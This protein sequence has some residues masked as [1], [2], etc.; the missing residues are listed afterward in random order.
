MNT[1]L[2]LREKR[3][4]IWNTAKEFLDQKRGADGIVP[5]EAAAEY[6]KME[7]D[8]VALG[9]EIER[10][11][12]QQAARQ[13]FPSQTRRPNRRRRKR[14]APATSTRRISAAICT[15]KPFC[16]TS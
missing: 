8:M 13:A 7:T 6:D 12:R 14:A 4:K 5:P 2:E 15:A 3:S 16:T 1:I 10:L 9:K 11:E